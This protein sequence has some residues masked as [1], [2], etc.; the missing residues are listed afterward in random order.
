MMI[1]LHESWDD[2]RNLRADWNRLLAES[3]SDTI[4][5]TWEWCE[6]WWNANRNGRSLFVLSAWEENELV[7]MA[8]FY[9]DKASHW[10]KAW[11]RLRM[12]GG[13]S[14]DSDYL[15]FFTKPGH[16][17]QILASFLAFLE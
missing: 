10:G 3:Y 14:G 9:A 1:A 7:G 12:L 4:F 2:L 6:A 16:E 5:L 13:G 17:R 15:D 11:T 8:P